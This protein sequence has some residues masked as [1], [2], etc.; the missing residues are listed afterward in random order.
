LGGWRIAVLRWTLVSGKA[1]LMSSA[2][3]FGGDGQ[4]VAFGK[5][6]GEI[7]VPLAGFLELAGG[8]R[9]AGSRGGRLAV[10]TVS[11]AVPGVD[12]NLALTVVI[13]TAPVSGLRFGGGERG[14]G[15]ARVAMAELGV[16]GLGQ[17]EPPALSCSV[18]CWSH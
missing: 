11:P 13:M 3:V 15:L 18:A 7:A 5:P 16:G 9:Q 14:P 2:G 12:R 6:G 10:V 17:A 8:L 4:P 1:G